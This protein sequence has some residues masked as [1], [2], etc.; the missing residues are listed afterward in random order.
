M[1][2]PEL[3]KDGFCTVS[4][5]TKRLVNATNAA[6]TGFFVPLRPIPQHAFGVDMAHEIIIL[7]ANGAGYSPILLRARR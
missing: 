1:T 6:L 7:G 5:M 2:S 4:Q 3:Q